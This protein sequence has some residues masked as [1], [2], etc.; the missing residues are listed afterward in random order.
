MLLLPL[1]TLHSAILAI[2]SRDA[3][4]EELS[5]R[6]V[7]DLRGMLDA[8]GIPATRVA[9][10]TEKSEMVEALV[11]DREA[12]YKRMERDERH[13]TVWRTMG[14][15]AVILMLLFVRE[16]LAIGAAY[17]SR[18][19]AA[20][21]HWYGECLQMAER[22]WRLGA[23][24]ALVGLAA[25]AL[26]DVFQV[27]MTLSVC[28]SWGLFGGW[29]RV[30]GDQGRGFQRGG[31]WVANVANGLWAPRSCQSQRLCHRKF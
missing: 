23:Y 21:R 14:I 4:R 15:G 13:A 31:N 18:Q 12:D 11:L 30:C 8:I 5:T 20:V 2:P 1:L 6:R 24:S 10:M 9:L 17:L 7:R 19:F 29:L 22:S 16:P 3:I 27:W 25:S 28:A 26:I